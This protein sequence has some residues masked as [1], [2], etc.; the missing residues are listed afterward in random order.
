MESPVPESRPEKQFVRD[1]REK[2]SIHS[3][4]L[5]KDKAL[6]VGKNGKPYVSL[7][8][9]DS[10]GAIDAR[11]WDNVESVAN[12]FQAGDIVRVK[13]VVQLF[14]SR[15]QVVVHK[16][17]KAELGGAPMSDF[18]SASKRD[19]QEMLAQLVAIAEAL[20][21]RCVR[22]LALDC[23]ADPEVRPRL[24]LA[25]AAK[26]IHHAYVGGLLD[27]VLSICG[28]MRALAAH[29][30][31]QGVKLN[32]DYLIF[33]GIF[34]DLGKIWEFELDGAVAYSD[35]GRL[36]GHMV[37]AV[38][39]IERKAA[40]ILGFPEE[41]KD[42]LKHIVLSHHGKHEYGSPKTPMFLEAFIVAAI[43]DLDSKIACIDQ[44]IQGEAASGERWSRHNALFERAFFLKANTPSS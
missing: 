44:F 26:S 35:K 13:G 11:V 40:R 41:L 18:V 27:H 10:S 19:P 3:L 32:L 14:Q 43:D 22:Q 20:E 15:R 25:P 28:I 16:L 39:L 30:Q 34:H 37:M 17:E 7:S 38:E 42:L 9:A 8:L 36:L 2:Q 4:F 6:L 29:Y 33:G 1:L 31:S 12:S 21:D 23:L 5:A 24:L